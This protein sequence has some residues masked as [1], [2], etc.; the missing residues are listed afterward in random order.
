MSQYGSFTRDWLKGFRAGVVKSFNA[1]YSMK[2][3]AY[4]ESGRPAVTLEDL[5]NNFRELRELCVTHGIDLTTA[6]GRRRVGNGDESG[7][8]GGKVS[9]T[10]MHEQKGYD[11]F[12]NR[13][14]RPAKRVIGNKHT[15]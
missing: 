10:A 12:R 2:K 5:E 9:S 11:A 13:P 6:Q 7:T 3:P 1:T 8:S 15:V 14:A 4:L